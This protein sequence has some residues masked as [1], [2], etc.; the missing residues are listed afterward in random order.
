MKK[1]F[2]LSFIAFIGLSAYSQEK[3]VS[4]HETAT[5]KNISV[6]YGRPYKK[7]RVIFGGLVPYGKVYRCGADSAT[8]V[9]FEKDASFGGKSVKAGTYTLFVIPN[10]E[11]WTIILNSQLGQW[12]AYSYDK[13]KDK[14]VLHVDVPV[15]K[16][17]KL[18]EQLTIS[19]PAH[20]MIIE[21]DQTKLIIPVHFS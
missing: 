3:V 15:K 16:T 6:R 17:D 8:T 18:I 14:D 5:G 9:T 10:K 1:M 19:L 2:L 13:N 7:G 4:P 12:G 20:A 21:W 11:S